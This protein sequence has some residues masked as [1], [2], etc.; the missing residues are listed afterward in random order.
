MK[1]SDFFSFEKLITPTVIKIVYWV[2][3]IV[4]LLGGL[5]S[6]FQMISLDGL[7]ALL[8]L[9]G[10]LIGLLFWRVF[11][12]GVIVAFNMLARMTEIRDALTGRTRP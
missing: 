6:F 12:E 10:T 4:I 11:C 7:T 9:V 5:F 3:L 8:T 1:F 2:G